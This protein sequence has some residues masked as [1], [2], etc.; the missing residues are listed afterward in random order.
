MYD[1]T[2]SKS[3]EDQ[4]R[5]TEAASRAI[6]AALPDQVFG[7]NRN[8]VFVSHQGSNGQGSLIGKTLDDVFSTDIADAY[9]TAVAQVFATR[10]I[11]MC[12]YQVISDH[13][14]HQYEARLALVADDEAVAI[15]RNVSDRKLLE[16]QL[17]QSQKMEAIGRLAG[18]LAHDFNNL[19]TVVQGNAHLLLEEYAEQGDARELAMHIDS[20]A[21]RGADL[22]RQLLA[23]GRR[24]VLQ[25]RVLDLNTV[26]ASVHALLPR[27]IGEDI[28]IELTLDPALWRVRADPGQIEQVIVNIAAFSKDRMPLGGVLR[29]ATSNAEADLDSDPRLVTLPGG[30]AVRIT[31]QDNGPELDEITR[32]HVFEPFYGT[33]GAGHAGLG[34][35]TVYGIVTQSGGAILL[36]DAPGGGARFQILLPP[37]NPG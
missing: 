9:R 19:L 35:A 6:L 21:S 32:A 25:P 37:V 4:L 7:L 24:Q 1:L 27:L 8:G 22:V 34:L 36:D 28:E 5:R 20:A 2:R 16:D 3:A 14:A 29:I 18:G 23:F 31:I 13:G 12:E 33:I 30:P 17:R 15:V 26:I 10:A 11:Q